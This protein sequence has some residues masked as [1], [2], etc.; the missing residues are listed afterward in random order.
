MFLSRFLPPVNRAMRTLDRTF[1]KKMVPV[2][3]ARVLD[4]TLLH[5]IKEKVLKDLIPFERFNQRYVFN[6]RLDVETPLLILRP[7]VKY[8]GMEVYCDLGSTED[9]FSVNG[10][11]FNRSLDDFG[12]HAGVC[13]IENTRIGTL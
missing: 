10:R 13:E 1:F 6:S 4:A 5:T 9:E 12:S 7:E 2:T 8:D 3:A 11:I